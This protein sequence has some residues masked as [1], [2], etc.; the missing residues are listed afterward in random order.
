MAKSTWRFLSTQ[1]A[2]AAE[3]LKR[4]IIEGEKLVE[5]MAFGSFYKLSSTA[6]VTFKSRVTTAIARQML[7]SHDDMQVSS[8]LIFLLSSQNIRLTVA[9]F[10]HAS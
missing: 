6:F 9:Y 10:L 8:T 3:G 1:A 2:D 5:M 7:I 4:G